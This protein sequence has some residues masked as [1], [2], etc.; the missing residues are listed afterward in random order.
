MLKR[1]FDIIVSVMLIVLLIPIFLLISII[2]IFNSKGGAIFSQQRVGKNGK[3]F[4]LYKFRTMV[5]NQQ[6][7]SL[8]TVGEDN[9]ITTIGKWLRKTKMDELPQLF[10]ILKG[11]MSFVGPRPEV[12]KYVEYYTDEQRKV[13]SVKPGLTDIASLVY[14]NESEELAR[15]GN[16]EEYYIRHI[17]PK[18][19]NLS[20]QY[21]EKQNFVTD[22]VIIFKTVLKILKTNR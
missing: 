8:L 6:N 5:I 15:A 1:L 16:P 9:R 14:I 2:I 3:L 18:K 22:L 11:D 10:N 13:L 17:L 12:P 4:T 20:L 19:L 21:I 7:K